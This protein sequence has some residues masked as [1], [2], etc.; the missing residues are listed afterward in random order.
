MQAAIGGLKMA[1][2]G[3]V[4]RQK[5]RGVRFVMLPV[6]LKVQL[7]VHGTGALQQFRASTIM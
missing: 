5:Q 2:T 7:R 3:P 6:T 4:V 1:G